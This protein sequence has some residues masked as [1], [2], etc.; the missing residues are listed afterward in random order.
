VGG[1][2]SVLIPTPSHAGHAD[3][4]AAYLAAPTARPMREGRTITGLHRSGRLLSLQVSLAPVHF[5]PTHFAHN[6]HVAAW[7]RKIPASRPGG[8]S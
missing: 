6:V 3:L 8:T 7:I 4:F 1:P 2:L 5:A